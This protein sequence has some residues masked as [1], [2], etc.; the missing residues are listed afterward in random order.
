MRN[1]IS[2]VGWI[3]VD[4]APRDAGKTKENPKGGQQGWSGGCHP[5][6]PT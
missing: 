4:K 1:A 6:I 3:K 2:D 5:T